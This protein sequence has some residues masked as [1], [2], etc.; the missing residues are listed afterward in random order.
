MA[1]DT[2]Q[3]GYLIDPLVPITDDN[4]TTI[5]GG[6]LRVYIAGSSTPVITY[7]N[8]D[9]AANEQ[10]IELDNSGRC[11][12]PVIVNKSLAYKVVVYDAQH[13][14][15]TPII[16]V[17]KMF[18]IGASITAGA[19]ATVVTGINGLTTKPDGFVDAS[20]IGTDG[21]VALDHTIVDDDLDTD[22][23]ATAV[24]NDRYIPLLNKDVND[25]DS[26]MALGRLWKWVLGKIKSLSTTITSFR[27]GDV[28]PVDGPDGT[29]K[30]SKDDLL[31]NTA[32]NAVGGFLQNVLAKNNKIG[33]PLYDVITYSWSEPTGWFYSYNAQVQNIRTVERTAS[34]K[35]KGF[36]TLHIGLG[37]GGA[38]KTTYVASKDGFAVGNYTCKIA[39]KIV[40]ACERVQIFLG[41]S[42]YTASGDE[43]AE[44]W[45]ELTFD[46]NLSANQ[47]DAFWRLTIGGQC[48]V[49][50]SP[51]FVCDVVELKKNLLACDEL[52]KV[53][54]LLVPDLNNELVFP[55]N[56]PIVVGREY[57]IFLDNIL[58]NRRSE[59]LRNIKFDLLRSYCKNYREFVRITADK[60]RDWIDRF[61]CA[62]YS[63]EIDLNLSAFVARM[64]FHFVP[65]NA[66]S[67]RS[68]KCMFI[69]DS[70]TQY[71]TYIAQLLNIFDDDVVSCESV[72]T[73]SS[74]AYDADNTQRTI[75]HEGRGG[76]TASD[77]C[78]QA[79][80]SGVTNPFYNP[81][82]Q[83]FDFSYYMAN[84]SVDAPD[85]V[86]V[87]LGT[88]DMSSDPA[89][90]VAHYQE[91]VDSIKAYNSNIFVFVNMCVPVY[92]YA[93]AEYSGVFRTHWADIIRGVL[94]TFG[95]VIDSS[96]KMALPCY[97][98]FDSVNDF[99]SFG[100][101]NY[102]YN[103][104][105]RNVSDPVHPAPTGYYKMAETIFNNL[106]YVL[107]NE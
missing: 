31:R 56:I 58:R 107:A 42:S 100:N 8:Y 106:K 88:N 53:Y 7:R 86:F 20:V 11:K 13:S 101:P 64:Q 10:T 23:K 80:K 69:G 1:L 26:K 54:D 49:Y 74:T 62:I 57:G 66:G 17:D 87:M 47:T 97:L 33:D 21:Y 34:V 60:T 50:F 99:G 65:A 68:I 55:A 29:A 25:P 3:Y 90:V 12:Y 85:F 83:E 52:E 44:G 75:Y 63:N 96:K 19:G 51:M 103:G 76:W 35:Y 102:L 14:Q 38:G 81:V 94:K 77:Y 27:T 61:S 70:L 4:G 43:L 40:G 73:R 9:G 5:K 36:P 28:I 104:D 84:Q 32:E 45:H 67:G 15:E 59:D 22:A 89:E 24:E 82:S 48:D 18:A 105:Y 79:S 95:S 92:K 78:T 37:V 41:D 93:Y 6:F 71:A 39:Y 2:N 91:M 30:M 98:F 46:K 72:G 16:T